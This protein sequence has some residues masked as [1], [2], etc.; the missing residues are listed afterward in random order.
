V[1]FAYWQRHLRA[2][3]VKKQRQLQHEQQHQHICFLFGFVFVCWITGIRQD[4][5]GEV[6]AVSIQIDTERFHLQQNMRGRT[7]GW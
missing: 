7:S 2:G 3:K 6:F 1:N 4:Y 5:H